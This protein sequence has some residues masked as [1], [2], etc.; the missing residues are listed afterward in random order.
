V[1]S[2][3]YS[4]DSKKEDGTE[5]IVTSVDTGTNTVTVS[6]DMS[7]VP[8]VNDQIDLIGFGDKGLPYR[9]L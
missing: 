9:L 7:F 8:S 6:D 3:D 5:S 2:P 1:H 4:N